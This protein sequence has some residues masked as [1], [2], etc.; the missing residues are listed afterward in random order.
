M[1]LALGS[2]A[3]GACGASLK[4]QCRDGEPVGEE[5]TIFMLDLQGGRIKPVGLAGCL[6]IHWGPKFGVWACQGD[7]TSNQAVWVKDDLIKVGNA[8]RGT[9]NLKLSM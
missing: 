4:F 9:L 1:Q 3:R 2:C 7:S 8:S 5:C 6:D